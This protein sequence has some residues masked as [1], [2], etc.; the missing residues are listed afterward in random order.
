MPTNNWL[1][2][3][4]EIE[5]IMLVL[6][7]SVLTLE[8]SLND[9]L[10]ATQMLFHLHNCFFGKN[11]Y[12]CFDFENSNDREILFNREKLFINDKFQV[13]SA[14]DAFNAMFYGSQRSKFQHIDRHSE[15][16]ALSSLFI[17]LFSHSIPNGWWWLK[18][19]DAA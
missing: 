3:W 9:V 1:R 5:N 8:K 17:L 19:W 11:I 10:T 12:G 6:H 7:S 13:L 16:S 18:I 14:L 15:L 2:L 4:Y